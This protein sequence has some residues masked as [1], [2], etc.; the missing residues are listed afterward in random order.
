M[1]LSPVD[2]VANAAVEIA[3]KAVVI[4]HSCQNALEVAK[5]LKSPLFVTNMMTS[6]GTQVTP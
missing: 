6:A 3:C 2:D 4:K 5:G 1:T